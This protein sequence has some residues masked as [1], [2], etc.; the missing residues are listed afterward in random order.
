[1]RRPETEATQRLSWS[2]LLITVA[3]LFLLLIPVWPDKL[4]WLYAI[5]FW[6]PMIA[7]YT[8]YVLVD[9]WRR[10][11]QKTVDCPAD[12]R[13]RP[14]ALLLGKT[15]ATRVLGALAVVSLVFLLIRIAAKAPAAFIDYV[16]ASVL[17]ITAQLRAFL[18]G[19]NWRYA[20]Y[21]RLNR[22]R[23]K[24]AKKKKS[25]QHAKEQ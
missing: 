10:N 16:A 8:F 1:M 9:R 6:I 3:G 20:I 18:A 5:L 23:L 17:F 22:R 24:Q 13:G 2:M 25:T 12:L 7:A 21:K 19:R 14:G 4:L 11:D 15:R